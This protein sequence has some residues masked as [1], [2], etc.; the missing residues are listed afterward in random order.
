[1]TGGP[2]EPSP[3]QPRGGLFHDFVADNRFSDRLADLIPAAVLRIAFY[4]RAIKY[5]LDR[6]LISYRNGA[7]PARV[8]LDDETAAGLMLT[9]AGYEEFPGIPECMVTFTFDPRNGGSRTVH[10]LNIRRVPPLSEAEDH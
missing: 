9:D 8:H 10:L 3:E 1:M 4:E 2:A 6:E 5:R 7:V